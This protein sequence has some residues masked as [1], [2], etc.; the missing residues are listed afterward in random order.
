[1]LNQMYSQLDPIPGFIRVFFI[2]YTDDVPK[3]LPCIEWAA[4]TVWSCPRLFP[5]T[6]VDFFTV[7]E[8]LS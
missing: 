3:R 2:P 8:V 7:H 6:E 1:M 5:D 4:Q